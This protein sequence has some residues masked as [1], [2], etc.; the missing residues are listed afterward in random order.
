MIGVEYLF[1]RKKIGMC[2]VI[3]H[4]YSVLYIVQWLATGWY[5][6]LGTSIVF[7]IIWVRPTSIKL[8]VS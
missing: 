1:D 8:F 3:E 5:R 4:F 6:V 7:Y 2:A